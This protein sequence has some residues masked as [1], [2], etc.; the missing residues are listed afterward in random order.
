MPDHTVATAAPAVNPNWPP[1]LFDILFVPLSLGKFAAIHKDD[2]PKIANFTWRVQTTRRPGKFYAFTTISMHRLITGAGLGELVDHQ[3]NNG[4]DNRRSNLRLCDWSSNHA[5]IHA[6]RSVAGYKGVFINQET[7][8]YGARLAFRGKRIYL[9]SFDTPEEAARAYDA[10]AL[11]TCGEFAKLNFPDRIGT[12]PPKTR[13]EKRS[14]PVYSDRGE[15]WDT[16]RL[17]AEAL[18]TTPKSVGGVIHSGKKC[19]GRRL[20]RR[21]FPGVQYPDTPVGDHGRKGVSPWPT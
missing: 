4:L 14:R 7:G 16:T 9:G 21:P 17:A 8:A 6:V 1:D 15:R 12:P 5:N 19:W 18:S 20:S 11:K 3:N 10:E 13:Q 2:Y